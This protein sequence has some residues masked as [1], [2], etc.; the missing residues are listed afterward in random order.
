LNRLLER[1]C[2]PRKEVTDIIAGYC[3]LEIFV[4][5]QKLEF[6]T[7]EKAIKAFSSDRFTFDIVGIGQVQLGFVN[8]NQPKRPILKF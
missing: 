6:L 8:P 7:Y 3:M 5:G 4:R 1:C 2:S